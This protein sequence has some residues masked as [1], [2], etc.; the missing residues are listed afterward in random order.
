MLSGPGSRGPDQELR[1]TR[2]RPP[3]GPGLRKRGHPTDVEPW[4]RGSVAEDAAV[5]RKKKC[6]W[7][8]LHLTL[9]C[10]LPFPMATWKPEGRKSQKC[11]S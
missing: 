1:T 2:Q 11:N 4:G 3:A 7:F 8:R 9:S 5:L 6:P 10:C